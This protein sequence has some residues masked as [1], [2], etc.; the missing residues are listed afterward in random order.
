VS[1]LHRILNDL[2]NILCNVYW[3]SAL[4]FGGTWLMSQVARLERENCH[5]AFFV[6]AHFHSYESDL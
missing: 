3:G 6:M 5:F 2:D 4:S 1:H